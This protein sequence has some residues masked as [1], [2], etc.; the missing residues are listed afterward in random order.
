MVERALDRSKKSVDK[1]GQSI[2]DP[3]S[4]SSPPGN[5]IDVSDGHF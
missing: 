1:P 3:V 4:S 2:T 5:V